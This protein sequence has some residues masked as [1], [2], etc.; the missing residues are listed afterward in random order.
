MTM[1]RDDFVALSR[2]VLERLATLKLARLTQ[3]FRRPGS[4]TGHEVPLARS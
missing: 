1:A 2:R 4:L 3:P